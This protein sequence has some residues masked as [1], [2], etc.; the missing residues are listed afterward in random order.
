MAITQRLTLAEFLARPEEEPALELEPDGAV[1][2]KVTPRG[3]HSRLQL[4]LCERIIEFAESRRV[5]VAFPELRVVFGGAAYVPDVS[6]FAW[7]RIPRTSDDEI[8]D[9]FDIPP[10]VAI[11][12]VSPQQSPNAVLRRCVWYVEN[13]VAFAL[14]VDPADRSIVR[15]ER[16]HAARVLR[17]GDGIDF[18][19][20]LHG[21]RLTVDEV[22]A[23]LRL[24]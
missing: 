16:D 20:V 8:A 22:F 3:R 19:P 15:F 11:E 12:I 18:G 13:G 24:R 9:V 23:T 7:D 21:F 2:Q 6:V 14:L 4:V 5:A 10:D 17:A 1:V